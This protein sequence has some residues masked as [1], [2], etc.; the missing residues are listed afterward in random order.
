V[1]RRDRYIFPVKGNRMDIYRDVGDAGTGKS[2]E[3]GDG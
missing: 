2:S 3:Y 1:T